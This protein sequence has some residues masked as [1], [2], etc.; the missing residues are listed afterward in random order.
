MK[1]EEIAKRFLDIFDKVKF[2]GLIFIPN[3]TYAFMPN[4]RLG[5][6]ALLKVLDFKIEFPIHKFDRM[7][8]ASKR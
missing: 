6:E 2:G 4:S 7:V 1:D 5:A 8:I 3:T